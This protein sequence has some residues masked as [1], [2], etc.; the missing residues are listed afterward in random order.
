VLRAHV[1]RKIGVDRSVKATTNKVGLTSRIIE[2]VEGAL[3][4]GLP[5]TNPAVERS[6]P[7]SVVRV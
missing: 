6:G 5:G 3:D 2:S 1:D 4:T 7:G